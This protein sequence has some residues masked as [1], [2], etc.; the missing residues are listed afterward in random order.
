MWM[1]LNLWNSSIWSWW[2]SRCEISKNL[3]HTRLWSCASLSRSVRWNIEWITWSWP[4]SN[5]SLYLAFFPETYVSWTSVRYAK[6]SILLHGKRREE[7]RRRKGKIRSIE[8]TS[9]SAVQQVDAVVQ[10]AKWVN[11][12][13]AKKI[14]GYIITNS[15][16]IAIKWLFS[17][18]HFSLSLFLPFNI[19]NWYASSI[20]LSARVFLSF[21]SWDNKKKKEEYHPTDSTLLFKY[22]YILYI[23]QEWR[24]LI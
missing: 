4:W 22:I 2:I 21:C 15:F 10:L 6:W 12:L 16:S 17:L 3:S 24:L 23:Y 8:W 19:H 7:R 11:K 13:I 14:V 9:R 18:S 5:R 1:K 20:L